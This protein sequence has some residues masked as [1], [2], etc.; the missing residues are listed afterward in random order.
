[1]LYVGHKQILYYWNV[2]SN[3]KC[4]FVHGLISQFDPNNDDS[5]T[6]EIF[7]EKVVAGLKQRWELDNIATSQVSVVATALD[8]R[9]RQLKFLHTS[10]NEK[11]EV[12]AELVRRAATTESSENVPLDDSTSPSP[13]EK[14]ISALN[15]LLSEEEGG[16]LDGSRTWATLCGC[17]DLLK[18]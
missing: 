18:C 2:C 4:S 17:T 7:K 15:I 1:M 11:V 14:S 6:I 3:I 10:E 16:S 9:F 8:P 5:S 12:K 13:P